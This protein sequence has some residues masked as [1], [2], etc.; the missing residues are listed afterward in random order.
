MSAELRGRRNSDVSKAVNTSE[1]K[2]MDQN[3]SVLQVTLQ[4]SQEQAEPGEAKS[5]VR[6]QC[7]KLLLVFFVFFLIGTVIGLVLYSHWRTN[8]VPA[9]CLSPACRR[10]AE[11]FSAA[12]DPFSRPCDYFQFTC[13]ATL[14]RGRQRGKTVSH[15]LTAGQ[16]MRRWT[17]RGGGRMD[18]EAETEKGG[19]MPE[20]LPDRRTAL[21]QTIKEILESPVG[22]VSTH[23]VKEKAQRF[24][25][26]CM[27]FKPAESTNSERF[28]A[29]VQ[30]LGGWAAS[31]K[32]TQPDFNTTLALLMAQYNTFPFFN[33]Y[34]GPDQRK[35]QSNEGQH[36]IQIDQPDFQFPI[37][38]NSGTQR[39]KINIQ[40]LRPFF[41]SCRQ[42]MTLLDVPSSHTTLH[43]G[44]YV[45]L[46]ST[47]VTAT[48]PLTYRLSQKL[49]YH[50]IT[51]QELQLLAPAIDWLNCLKAVFHP[52]PVNQSDFVLLHNLPYIIY[53]SQTISEWKL[54]H[55]M[56]GSDPL[57]TYMV[58]TLLQTLLPALDSRFSQIMHS[59]SMDIKEG[60]PHWRHCVQ[61]SLKGFD[62]L[63][64]HV[65]KETYAHEKAEELMNNIYSTFKT[66]I[67]NLSWRD[68]GSRDL[69]LN[70][71][72]SLTPRLS[73]NPEILNQ[74]S[75]NSH[76]S[77][78]IISEADYF[79][80][81][82]QLLALQQKRRRKLLSHAAQ[83]DVLFV[84]LFLSG[85]DII[86]P[87]GM[88][89]SPLFHPSYPRAINYGM[90]GSMIAKDLLHLLLPDI[91]SQ[92]EVPR[93][94]SECVWEHYVSWREGSD[95][96]KSSSLSQSQQQ[97]VWV[98]YAALE[99]AL[100][101]YH[102]SLQRHS[103][104][105]SVSGLSHVHLFLSSFIQ[106]SCDFQ[107]YHAY[108]H[109]E[110]S[111]LVTV[112]CR[113]SDLCPKPLICEDSSQGHSTKP[114]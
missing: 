95:R 44:L 61:Q 88:F 5:V 28:L 89:V 45:S 6:G 103:D 56:M 107:P 84:S 78:V 70:K 96:D 19:D 85:N 58:L 106:A 48:S 31:G 65:I 50:R 113:N 29:L 82:L 66:K 35:D 36:Y 83:H 9:P 90:L 14:S 22:G 99:I 21:L 47:L 33:V 59:D 73:I 69:V 25:N 16:D 20:R 32:W 3:S 63:L 23:T 12:V 91:L 98:Q 1:K 72:K 55:E 62:L 108:M 40:S 2:D 46:S 34:V 114:C 24:Y 13:G 17:G 8:Q 27:D 51:L 54:K 100:Q 79:S 39:S 80:N 97:E 105:T 52:L 101:A 18:R 109:F 111:F 30:Q 75:L 67:I 43:C 7:L 71:V 93:L 49:L 81:Y 68:V 112:L 92:S 53:M 37:E 60:I 102:E 104:D 64:S 110:P 4:I 86:F 38:W 57:H 74:L 15:N 77:E 94:K 26:T 41:S 10:A 42:L 76:Y 11:R 87:V